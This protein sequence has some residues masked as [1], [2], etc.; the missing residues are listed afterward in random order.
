MA[1]AGRGELLL[2]AMK[3]RSGLEAALHVMGGKWKL[4]ILYQLH[5]GPRRFGELRRLVGSVSEKVLIQQ[6]RELCGDGVVLRKDMR[7]VPPHVE[8]RLT[9]FGRTLGLAAKPLCAWGEEYTSKIERLASAREA[10]RAES[11]E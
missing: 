8:Y 5:N 7:T 1:N 9:P 11:G 3:F 10:A 6:L 4:L 2:Q